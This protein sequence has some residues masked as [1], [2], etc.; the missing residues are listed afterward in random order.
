MTKVNRGRWTW[1][2]FVA[3]A[4][5]LL[6]GCGQTQYS[7]V[8]KE[9]VPPEKLSSLPAWARDGVP[10]H[11]FYMSGKLVSGLPAF[12]STP[13]DA[14]NCGFIDGIARLSYTPEPMPTGNRVVPFVNVAAYESGG[15]TPVNAGHCWY[16]PLTW[17]EGLQI[18]GL[19]RQAL[20]QSRA[21][22]QNTKVTKTTIGSVECEIVT[23]IVLI[24]KTY[25]MM[26]LYVGGRR[27][28]ESAPDRVM[29]A[30]YWND[31]TKGWV[32]Q[33]SGKFI[34]EMGNKLYEMA[35]LEI[36]ADN[37][38]S[39]ITIN[40]W[41]PTFDDVIG[42]RLE[43]LTNFMGR[44]QSIKYINDF[45][46][47]WKTKNMRAVLAAASVPELETMVVKLEKSI[48]EYDLASK[49]EKDSAQLAVQQEGDASQYLEVSRL[50]EQRMDI[51][52]SILDT[53]KQ[54]LTVRR[55]T[56]K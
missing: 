46:L 25:L 22:S 9:S 1:S 7:G 38:V 10:C 34:F 18:Q 27:G 54:V 19:N 4:V 31:A 47:E 3:I 37:A 28:T 33:I 20:E 48:L 23:E 41:E 13:E 26:E 12:A 36:G 53:T 16:G 50:F 43:F 11:V 42:G 21:A 17:L 29:A 8:I 45:L 52:T 39:Q 32:K 56:Q 55:K 35:N 14:K 15:R 5:A 40:Q 24:D 44:V 30:Y 51:M 49:K 2:A 6:A